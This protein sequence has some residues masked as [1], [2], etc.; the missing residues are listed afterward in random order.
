MTQNPLHRFHNANVLVTGANRGLGLALVRAALN[1]SARRVYATARDVSSLETLTR[2]D[3]E[4]V[5]ALQLDVNDADSVAR[6]A[7]RA[8]DVDIL[9]NNAG[10]LASFDVLQSKPEDI[11]LDFSTNAFGMLAMAKAF[12]PA[13]SRD[14]RGALVNVLS[15]VSLANMPALGGYSA[16]KSAAYSFTQALR[17]ELSRRGV[18]VHAVL[19][20]P[21]DTDMVRQMEMPKTDPAVVAQAILDGVNAG[22]YEI[23]PDPASREMYTVYK[24]DP[25][26]LAAQLSGM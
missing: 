20:G 16:A 15:I 3:P 23:L 6:A 17:P 2:T 10:I 7:E 25:Q 22:V 24:R 12:L 13:L 14:Q 5:V 21:I 18:S 9:V 11:L 1:A 8:P 26:A 4:R 19:P